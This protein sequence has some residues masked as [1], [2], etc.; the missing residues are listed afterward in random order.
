MRAYV[1]V[2]ACLLMCTAFAEAQSSDCASI[3]R[4]GD[5]ISVTANSWDPLQKMSRTLADTY[6][7]RVSVEDPKW[8]FPGDTEDVAVADPEYSATHGNIHYGVMRRHEI[9]VRFSTHATDAPANVAG[10]VQQ[11]ATE[12]NSKMPYGYRV[13]V[14]RN[15][16]NL[17]P[18]TT[19]GA[20]GNVEHVEPLLDRHVTIPRG[21]RV[22]SEHAKIMAD[23]LSEQTGLHVSC[24]QSLV[25]GVPWGSARVTFEAVNL[26]ARDV[27]ISLISF[28]QQAN[29]EA[30]ARHPEYDF[31]SVRC[32]G[33]G[34]PWC[35]IEVEA[36]FMA[37]CAGGD[38]RATVP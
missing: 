35:F 18:T 14:D 13:D 5:A 11:L 29:S 4:R 6:G 28:E 22:I 16:Y 32:D 34:A 10:V 30:S 17:V 9:Q 19:R 23:Q 37:R 21:I 8:A 27:L 24:C 31:W 15:I 3:S 1:C 20:D 25:A 38:A 7:I 36:K 2:L 12:A 33:T 26:P